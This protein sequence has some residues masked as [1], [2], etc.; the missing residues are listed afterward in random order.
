ME[1]SSVQFLYEGGFLLAIPMLYL[2]IKAVLLMFSNYV[3]F[4]DKI[5][6]MFLFLSSVIQLMFSTYPW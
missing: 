2:I 4:N 3:I 5:I 1:K 6:L